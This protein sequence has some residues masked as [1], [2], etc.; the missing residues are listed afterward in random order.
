MWCVRSLAHSSLRKSPI[1]VQRSFHSTNQIA[2]QPSIHP[3]IPQQIT[4]SL[5]GDE[6]D[7]W[8]VSH[9]PRPSVRWSVGSSDRLQRFE[10]IH[11]FIICKTNSFNLFIF[12]C[13]RC[14]LFLFFYCCSS[15]ILVNNIHGETTTTANKSRKKTQQSEKTITMYP[16]HTKKRWRRRGRWKLP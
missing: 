13:I 14:C 4:Q 10:I 11:F 16:R 9:Y 1:T 12:I 3:P 7:Q 6:V 2:S 5:M 8:P 15:T